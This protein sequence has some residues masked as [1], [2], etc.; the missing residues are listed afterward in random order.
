MCVIAV[1]WGTQTPADYEAVRSPN[2]DIPEI[3][4]EV[5]SSTDSDKTVFSQRG[6]KQEVTSAG[7]KAILSQGNL[8]REDTIANIK[9]EIQRDSFTEDNND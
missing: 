3:V 9:P 7:V 4:L 1:T 5:Q 6:I 8:S 2:V